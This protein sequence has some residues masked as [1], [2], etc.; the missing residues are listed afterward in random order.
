MCTAPGARTVAL[1]PLSPA[2]TAA[3]A[4]SEL[5]GAAPGLYDAVHDVTKGNPLYVRE[6]LRA[7][8][9]D[10]VAADDGARAVA[11]VSVPS[12]E[13]RVMRRVDRVAPEARALAT[14]MAV[15][16]DDSSLAL[17]TRLAGLDPGLAADI[18]HRLVRIEILAAEDP[19]AFVHPVVR[20]TVYD[21]LTVVERDALHLAAAELVGDGDAGAEAVA[22]HLAAVRPSGSARVAA[23]MCEAA[24]AALGRAAPGA[25]ARWL[26]RAVDE[27]A[28]DPP[29]PGLLLEL[30]RVE[31]FDRDQAAIAH[32][33]EAIELTTDPVLRVQ[34]A[35]LVGEALTH[36]GRWEEGL[37][38]VAV[39]RRALDGSHPDLQLE[40]T[41]FDALAG[42]YDPRRA[43]AFRDRDRLR[44]LARGD[45][46]PAL[47]LAALLAGIGGMRG[48][49]PAEVLELVEHA[50][51]DGL[52]IAGHGAGGWASGQALGGMIVIEEH[53]RA[54]AFAAE[55][56]AEARRTGA[57]LG[58]LSATLFR[59]WVHAKRGELVMAESLLRTAVEVGRTSDLAMLVT[60]GLWF[61]DDPLLE[62][63][64][65]DDIGM[66]VESIELDPGFTA[67]WSGAVVQFVRGKRRRMTGRLEEA[68]AD[69]RGCGET[70]DALGYGPAVVPWRSELALVLAADDPARAR[71]LAAHDLAAARATG[72]AR[73]EGV[74]LRVS[75][76]VADRDDAARAAARVDPRPRGLARAARARAL[77]RRARLGAAPARA[78]HGSP[79]A[80]A[81]GPGA[82]APLRRGPPRD[83]GA[84]G[85]PCRG[86][87]P[88][89]RRAQRRRCAHPERA[90]R[91]A[92]R[93]RR[94]L[95]PRGRAGP[96]RQPEDRRDPPVPRLREAR[97]VRAR[98]PAAA[99]PR[100]STRRPRRPR[101]SGSAHTVGAGYRSTRPRGA[102]IRPTV[103]RTGSPMRSVPPL[104]VPWRIVPCSL[105][106][107]Q[108]P[109]IRRTGSS[110][111]K[112][113]PKET[114]APAPITPTTS[115]SNSRSCARPSSAS[116]RS[117]T[118]QRATSSASRSMVIASRSRALVHSPT[119]GSRVRSG[120]SS[121]APT[122]CS[123]E[124]WQTMSG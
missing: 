123:S 12:L 65:L 117:R 3:L 87:A 109:R 47:A 66:L 45:T 99:S 11:E 100:C 64:S 51:R 29:R 120:G 67:T 91:R 24:D 32:L 49:P 53:D 41:V 25:A 90:A 76:V 27:Q 5:P 28:P 59:G 16:S 9:L 70:S 81:P 46:W 35:L 4:R 20:R 13:E 21:S 61:L 40:L 52:L 79:R 119:S 7:L 58:V 57:M 73:P 18:A 106:S 30:G 105:S 60:T 111:S 43:D 34:A 121:P 38:V 55:L 112:P 93:R 102:S 44:E 97:P 114:N 80:A 69:L 118:K 48:D 6:L 77:A 96:L 36:A 104:F 10:G 82:R 103:T 115:P 8:A 108:S 19:I 22:A 39:A 33:N 63:P 50:T 14:A 74:A 98:A 113:S 56:E 85:A 92:A 75:G 110:P 71:A 72:L 88:P 94:P 107:H 26:R 62:R 122:A 84:G 78:A 1:A 31:L 2:A 95:E 54:L 15:L 124:R 101:P 17:A 23:A 68:A 116:S 89:P 83:P 86:R 42:A 37:S